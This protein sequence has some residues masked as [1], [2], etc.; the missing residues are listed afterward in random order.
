M[1]FLFSLALYDECLPSRT[2]DFAQPSQIHRGRVA[3]PSAGDVV[4]LNISVPQTVVSFLDTADASIRVFTNNASGPVLALD[5]T[6]RASR[7][8]IADFGSDTG[9]IVL[10]SLSQTGLTYSLIAYPSACA[11]RITSTRESDSFSLNETCDGTCLAPGATICYFSAL[12]GAINYSL[13]VDFASSDAAVEAHTSGGL[14]EQFRGRTTATRCISARDDPI[15]WVVRNGGAGNLRRSVLI[16]ARGQGPSSAARGRRD[17]G[18]L[19]MFYAGE[20]APV[21][22]FFVMVALLHMCLVIAAAYLVL[23]AWQRAAKEAVER[24]QL[25]ITPDSNR[26]PK[27]SQPELDDGNPD[28]PPDA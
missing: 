11:S 4:C 5:S 13:S 12:H 24:G 10:R 20:P 15:F 1:L 9:V 26:P 7:L 3:F 17:S 16:D 25:E 2:S 21:G 6:F 18:G 14:W 8:A 22:A 23:K 19:Q 28:L 27:R